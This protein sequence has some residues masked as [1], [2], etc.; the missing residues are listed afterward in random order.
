MP[1]GKRFQ[2]QRVAFD[3]LAGPAVA[4]M[5]FSVSDTV[6]APAGAAPPRQEIVR[7]STAGPVPRL[8]VGARLGFSPRSVLRTFIGVDG[9]VGPARSA[10]TIDSNVP[11]LPIWTLGLALGATVGTE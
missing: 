1:L 3:V 10:A 5:G 7:E 8:L 2:F 11:E 4:M 9:E 6:M